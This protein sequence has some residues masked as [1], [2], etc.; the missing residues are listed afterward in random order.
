[1]LKLNFSLSLIFVLYLF[2]SGVYLWRSWKRGNRTFNW[3]FT[4]HVCYYY[5]SFSFF[6][7]L[8][9]DPTRKKNI[10]NAKIIQAT[11]QN[12]HIIKF[13]SNFWL[14]CFHIFSRFLFFL[15]HPNFFVFFYFCQAAIRHQAS[16]TLKLNWRQFKVRIKS[17]SCNYNNDKKWTSLDKIFIVVDI[18]SSIL[19]SN[20]SLS[21]ILKRFHEKFSTSED[22]FIAIPTLLWIGAAR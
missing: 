13:I 16:N 19:Y 9:R 14:F 20:T 15:T 6:F 7:S 22:I 10:W 12:S 4:S 5:F 1:M 3:N 17:L 18:V 11:P 8:V 2:I 21:T